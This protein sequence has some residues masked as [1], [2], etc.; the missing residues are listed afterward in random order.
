MNLGGRGRRMR[1]SGQP[2]LY[3]EF[4]GNLG[5]SAFT[6]KQNTKTNVDKHSLG[7]V[8]A[9]RLME[10]EAGIPGHSDTHNLNPS[11]GVVGGGGRWTSLHSKSVWS[12]EPSSRTARATQENTC[13]EAPRPH[14]TPEPQTKGE[15]SHQ[16]RV[17]IQMHW[18]W[19][20]VKPD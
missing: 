2:W 5:C 11:C 15:N 7:V 3:C 20:Q 14:K 17:Q 4:L 6:R 19:P 9:L 12:I 18:K 8:V 13:L 10:A 1:S 16:Q